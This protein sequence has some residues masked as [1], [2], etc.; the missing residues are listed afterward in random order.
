MGRTLNVKCFE[1]KMGNQRQRKRCKK[2]RSCCFD[3]PSELFGFIL[4]ELTMFYIDS[5]KF[6]FTS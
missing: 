4:S 6:D 1:I 3:Q 5:F 2:F